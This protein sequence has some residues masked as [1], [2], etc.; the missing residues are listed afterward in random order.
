MFIFNSSEKE[1]D[2]LEVIEQRAFLLVIDYAERMC[3]PA[4]I[5]GSTDTKTVYRNVAIDLPNGLVFV[6]SQDLLNAGY[7]IKVFVGNERDRNI[8][9]AIARVPVVTDSSVEKAL[10]ML[11]RAINYDQCEIT[12]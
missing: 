2:G 8:T 7:L 10:E 11:D 5:W 1:F 9:S 6:M 12:K 4:G 3:F